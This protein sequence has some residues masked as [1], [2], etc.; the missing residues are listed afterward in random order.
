MIFYISSQG[1]AAT[2]WIS[3]AFTLHPK[4]ICF[5]AIRSIPPVTIFEKYD[6]FGTPL[7]KLGGHDTKV[8]ENLAKSL[9]QCYV[10]SG[11]I[12][13]AVHT[14]WGL[15]CKKPIES[16]NGKFAGIIRHPILQFHSMMNAFLS[17]ELSYK[18]NPI[19]DKI[20][21]SYIDFFQPNSKIYIDSKTFFNIYECRSKPFNNVPINLKFKKIQLKLIGLIDQLMY[22]KN[23]IERKKFEDLDKNRI[24]NIIYLKVVN[25]IKD[26]FMRVFDDHN[27]FVFNLSEDLL[28]IMEKMTSDFDYFKLKFKNLTGI[29][30]PDHLQKS[31]Q[32]LEHGNQHSRNK[33]S[34]KEIW[35]LWPMD[36][37]N[38]FLLELSNRPGLKEFYKKINYWLP[39]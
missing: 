11:K 17:S 27:D 8:A 7:H 23:N 25:L 9:N 21:Y 13:G 3:K 22:F 1:H 37:R 39:E 14:I 31:I 35:S 15:K 19:D 24:I 26:S 16:F 29:D 28:I 38:K 5:H 6:Y 12:F 32:G 33:L 30:Y 2:K 36:I 10:H 18:Q 20:G 4:V 34:E